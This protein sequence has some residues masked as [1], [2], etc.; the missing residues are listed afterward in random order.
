[1]LSKGLLSGLMTTS[2][3]SLPGAF[4]CFSLNVRNGLSSLSLENVLLQTLLYLT[5][6][7]VRFILQEAG[8]GQISMVDAERRLLANA[9]LDF[10][11]ER[12][13]LL[14]ESCIPVQNFTTFYDL[15]IDSKESNVGTFDDPGP[16]GRGRYTEAFSPEVD[17]DHWRKGAQWFEVSR[18]HAVYI[19]SDV[20]YYP[21]FRDFCVPACYV[22]EH[23]IST[24]M[25]IEFPDEISTRSI[26]SVDWSRGGSH[27]ATF[28]ANDINEWLIRNIVNSRGCSINGKEGQ[29][30]YF[31]ARKF[32]PNTL[33][34]L[35]KLARD[36]IGIH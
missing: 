6:A 32:S 26:T 17:I 10:T 9:L 20:K 33:E 23:Y 2:H 3:E 27:P 29:P 19:I 35:L 18:K 22:D 24:M 11:N 5:S 8:W 31:F 12:F 13:V 21:K 14:S 30:C 16:F 25:Y 4:N 36:E 34:P 7:P 28:N 1:M 15:M